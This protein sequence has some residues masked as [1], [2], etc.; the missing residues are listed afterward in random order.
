[1]EAN[2]ID[3]PACQCGRGVWGRS[4]VGGISRHRDGSFRR[5]TTL[6]QLNPRSALCPWQICWFSPSIVEEPHHSLTSLR[7]VTVE[8]DIG[9]RS[10]RTSLS[11]SS[12]SPAINAAATQHHVQL[13]TE[14][15]VLGGQHGSLEIN[16]PD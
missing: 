3:R 14:L 1:M 11:T 9:S 13:C 2:S 6:I 12:L 10:R 15:D 8:P 5:E 16:G 7:G 4:S